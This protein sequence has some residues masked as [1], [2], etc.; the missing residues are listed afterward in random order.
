MSAVSQSVNPPRVRQRPNVQELPAPKRDPL[1]LRSFLL[2]Q[3]ASAAIAVGSAAAALGMYG[4]TV[5]APH[6]WNQEFRNLDKLQR[7]ERHLTATNETLKHNFAVR[8]ETPSSG[9]V[10]PDPSKS[11]FLPPNPAISPSQEVAPP[12]Q[13]TS[14]PLSVRGPLAY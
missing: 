10:P 2:L 5:Y 12:H 13:P 7:Y 3:H 9:F 11:I 14:Q 4:W 1:W 6:Q 8:S